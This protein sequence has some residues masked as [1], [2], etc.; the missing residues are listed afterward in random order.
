MSRGIEGR[1]IFNDDDDRGTFLMVFGAELKRAGHRCYAWAL[2]KN[3]YHLLL[4]TSDQPLG[5]MMRR[6]NSTFARYYGKKYNRRGYLFQDRYKSIA[7]Q[8][9]RYVEEMVRYIHLNPVRAGVC[10]TIE[11]LDRYRWTG[12]SVILG[13]QAVEFQDTNP[14]IKRFGKTVDVARKNYRTFVVD[15]LKNNAGDTLVETIR[16][17]NKGSMDMRYSGGWV[18]G[19]PEFVSKAVQADSQNRIRIARY[20]RAGWDVE[21]LANFVAQK[22]MV[23]REQLKYKSKRTP[24][25]AARKVIC[26]LGYRTLEIPATEL[27]RFLGISLPAVSFAVKT[28]EEIAEEMGIELNI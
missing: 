1:D 25:A 11:D 4:R 6:L 16:K 21:K 3:H 26:Y 24:Y 19:D 14:I 13:T 12:H 15:G 8:E 5:V 20:Q 2:M 9:Q 28:G 10:S 7:T 23:S 18:I 17:S 22:M 27:G